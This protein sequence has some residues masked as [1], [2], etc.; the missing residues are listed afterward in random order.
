MLAWRPYLSNKG[1]TV[2]DKTDQ[3]HA[4]LI[5]ISIIETPHV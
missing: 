5:R 4:V 3:A 2:F 1:V